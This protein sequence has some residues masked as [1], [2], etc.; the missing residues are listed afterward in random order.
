MSSEVIDISCEMEVGI[1]GYGR[2][3]K[4]KK[5]F[6]TSIRVAKFTSVIPGVFGY[7]T[8]ESILVKVPKSIIGRMRTIHQEASTSNKTRSNPNLLRRGFTNAKCKQS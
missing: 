8:R 6:Q 5:E 4:D 2:C 7:E 3:W 1:C